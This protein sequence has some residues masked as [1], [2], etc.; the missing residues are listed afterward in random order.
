MCLVDIDDNACFLEVNDAFERITGYRRDETIGRTSTE[1]G[2]YENFRDLE[3]SRRRLLTEGGYRNLEVPF[4]KK[5][6]RGYG[7]PRFSGAN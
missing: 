3:Q 6:W 2:L 5:S 1:L 7:R 4:R